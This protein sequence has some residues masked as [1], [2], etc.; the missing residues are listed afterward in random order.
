MFDLFRSREKSV[1]Y[2]L[3][4]LLSLVALSLVITLIPGI[5]GGYARTSDINLIAEIGG[6]P[7]TA[8]ELRQL[9]QQQMQSGG[10]QRQMASVYVPLMAQELIATRAVAY[11]AE[12]MG[13]QVNDAEAAE[14]IRSLL[15]SLFEGGKFAGRDMYA[16]ILAQQNL[17]IPSFEANIK[18]QTL[19]TRLEVLAL[20]GSIVTPQEVEN[21]YR[22]KNDRIVISYALLT[23]D[24]FKGS[25]TVTPEEVRKVYDANP[26][27]YNTPEKRTFVAYPVEESKSPLG[28]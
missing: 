20:E 14:I 16:A 18:R 17:T 19:A 23:A 27:V 13:F 15:P 8:Q 10:L 11:Q 26:A 21:A 3:I 12:R 5:G 6:E 9:V 25:V 24:K 22:L 2:I 7:V 4:A 1:R 28:W